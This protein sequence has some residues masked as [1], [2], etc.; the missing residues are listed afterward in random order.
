MRSG[1][2]IQ[3]LNLFKKATQAELPE[4]LGGSRHVNHEEQPPRSVAEPL[5]KIQSCTAQRLSQGGAG[6][7]GRGL[8]TQTLRVALQRTKPRET[9]QPEMCSTPCAFK[10]AWEGPTSV[11]PLPLE[12]G[13]RAQGATCRR[14][15]AACP[16][17]SKSR[18]GWP[19]RQAFA[20]GCSE[21]P[22][23]GWFVMQLWLTVPKG[24]QK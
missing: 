7:D 13:G 9:G 12:T 2:I 21:L 11:S 6:L 16:V 14:P 8:A 23:V 1:S 10:A 20:V 15:A 19:W 3:L 22:G 5:G 4:A 17:P 18:P 24:P